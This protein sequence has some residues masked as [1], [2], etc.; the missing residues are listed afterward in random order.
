LNELTSTL[1]DKKR[2]LVSEKNDAAFKARQVL[3]QGFDS[4]RIEEKGTMSSLKKGK[5]DYMAP[6]QNKTAYKNF[7]KET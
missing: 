3:I 1:A 7:Y 5:N 2:K 6:K 4:Y